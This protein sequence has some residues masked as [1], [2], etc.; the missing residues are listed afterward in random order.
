M[1]KTAAITWKD[2]TKFHAAYGPYLPD[3]GEGNN[4][5]TQTAAAVNKLIYKWFNDG[6]VYDNTY[7]LPGW[8]N[9]LSSYANWLRANT[10]E[11]ARDTLDSIFYCETED[12]YAELLYDLAENLFD[13]AYLAA[14]AI[15]PK[16]G[17]IYEADG[18]YSFV[19]PEGSYEDGWEDS[20]EEDWEDEYDEF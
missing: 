3:F 8:A 15:A 1:K 13:P 6:D 17:S 10:T 19:D 14:A 20:H 4:R 16:T 5:A 7:S 12:D 11:K 2:F 18:P 9:D